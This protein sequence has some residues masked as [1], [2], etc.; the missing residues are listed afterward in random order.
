MHFIIKLTVLSLQLTSDKSFWSLL[1]SEYFIFRTFCVPE[2][3]L[4]IPAVTEETP[5]FYYY[6]VTFFL[7]ERK[8]FSIA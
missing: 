1:V 7:Q 2:T 3:I 4:Q 8:N 5:G 6:T